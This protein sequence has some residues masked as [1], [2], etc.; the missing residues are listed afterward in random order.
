MAE[1]RS[2]F[3]ARP[4]NCHSAAVRLN[5]R[6]T[7]MAERICLSKRPILYRIGERSPYPHDHRWRKDLKWRRR[8][9]YYGDRTGLVSYAATHYKRHRLKYGYQ[10][11]RL[12]ER[13]INKLLAPYWW[14]G[15]YHYERV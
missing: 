10:C 14:W 12:Q 9:H 2:I 3:N 15:C 7:D 11:Y 8:Q 5:D 1:K 4:H 6:E 13:A